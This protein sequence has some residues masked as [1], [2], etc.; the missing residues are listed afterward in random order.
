MIPMSQTPVRSSR[1]RARPSG[2][3]LR[4]ARP[5]PRRPALL[6]L[7]LVTLVVT[8]GLGVVVAEV[9]DGAG[10]DPDTIPTAGGPAP[11]SLDMTGFDATHIIDDAVFYDSTTMDSQDVSDFIAQVNDRCET[12]TDGTVC[13][14]DA[15]F[16]TPDVDPTTA[17]PGGYVG[18]AD[19]SAAAVI[20]QVATSCDV[21][22]QV[23]LTLL[24]KEQG[25]LTAS[26]ASLSATDYRSATGYGCPDGTSCDATYTGFFNQV[27][28]AAAQFQRY[29]LDPGSYQVVAG[30]SAQLAYSPDPTC[31]SAAITVVN[32]ATAGLY[33]YTP[34]QPNSAAAQGGDRCT[35]WGN[36]SF[37]GYFRT[38]F[39][40]PAPSVAD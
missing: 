39:G 23:L 25:L 31:G 14:A 18:A 2:T 24:Q 36:W 7:F 34:Y 5:A 17:C 4:Q 26:G 35:S 22:P 6:P 33:D 30:T 32:Q 13:L 38:W 16:D 20:S 8:I 12:G 21:N 11:V 29:R 40:D 27:Y 28:G 19:E 10:H 1:A 9:V 3:R 15:T 37:Y